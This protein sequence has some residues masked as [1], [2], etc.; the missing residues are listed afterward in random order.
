MRR[1][2]LPWLA[3]VSAVAFAILTASTWAAGDPLTLW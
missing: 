3:C 1:F 2:Q